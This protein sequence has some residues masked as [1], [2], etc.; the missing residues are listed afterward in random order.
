MKQ[1]EENRNVVFSSA[2]QQSS[3]RIYDHLD[4]CKTDFKR[5]DVQQYIVVTVHVLMNVGI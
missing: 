2:V 3:G 4:L 1:V 5:P